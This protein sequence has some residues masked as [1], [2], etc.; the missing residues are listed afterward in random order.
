MN[1]VAEGFGDCWPPSHGCSRWDEQAGRN[2][3]MCRR[4]VY[5]IRMQ[6]GPPGTELPGA[7]TGLSVV[8]SCHTLTLNCLKIPKIFDITCLAMHGTIVVVR[9]SLSRLTHHF[10]RHSR[11]SSGSSHAEILGQV[12]SARR[13]RVDRRRDGVGPLAR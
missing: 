9:C 4:L 3:P 1:P 10:K 2:R 12:V 6:V 5:Q 7:G 11:G 8:R 13:V